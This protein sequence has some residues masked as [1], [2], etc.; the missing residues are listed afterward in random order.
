M[1]KVEKNKKKKT[2]LKKRIKNINWTRILALILVITM[3]ASFVAGL[4]VYV[5]RS[6]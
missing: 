6:K 1:E 2:S 5:S 4:L 3:L